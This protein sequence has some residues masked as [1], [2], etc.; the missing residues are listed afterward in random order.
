M[1]VLSALAILSDIDTDY[2][3]R[4]LN[5]G[6]DK[7]G[8]APTMFIGI[9]RAESQKSCNAVACPLRPKAD[10]GDGSCYA[11]GGTTAC[12]I[13]SM[14]RAA[15]NGKDYSM[16]AALETRSV[17]AKAVRL[18][19]IGD[20]ACSP[21]MVAYAVAAYNVAKSAGLR[22]LGYTH[23]HALP[24]AAPLKSFLMASAN[25]LTE[26]DKLVSEGWRVAV[27]LPPT[28]PGEKPARTTL[29]P[30]GR[31]VLTCPVLV[32]PDVNLDC[33]HCG[34]CAGDK[35]G[36]IIGFPDHGPAVQTPGRIA[37][38]LRAASKRAASKG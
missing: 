9:D 38:R 30:E 36:P 21:S 12:A 33:N 31:T 7:V 25:S 15:D 10:G 22:V 8:D 32:R 2:S 24:H 35:Q 18:T 29:T 1:S 11:Q 23:G 37:A 28:P 27:V 6:S 34:L 26:A 16:G 20:V 5:H 3:V 4:W 14:K 19:A 17:R 13:G